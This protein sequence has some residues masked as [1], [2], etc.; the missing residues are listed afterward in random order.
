[1]ALSDP[2]AIY[3]IHSVSPYSRTTGLPYGILKVLDGSSLSLE[4]EII[5]LMGG[6]SK[7]AWASE[8]GAISSDISLKVNQ[9]EDFMFELFLGKAPTANAAE[10]AGNVATAVNKN[11][12]SVIQAVTG[13]ASV[14]VIPSTGAAN[15]K[16]G[17]Y[18]IKVISA[19][20]VKVY[21]LSDVDI[22]RGTNASYADDQLSVTSA[23]LTIT[24]A[25]ST[26]IA[27][28]GIRLSGGSGT[29][30]MTTGDTATFE[31]R[32]I[33]TKSM[34]VSIGSSAD[35][36]FPEFGMIMLAQRRGNQEMFELDALRCKAAG[37][38]FPFERNA[39]SKT[40]L[41]VKAL[42]DSVQ[43]AVFKI[44]SAAAV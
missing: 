24:S 34:T 6:S 15:L 29:I 17:K 2:R 41:K 22:A 1:M 37:M 40:E 43:D 42:Y 7:Y 9:Y 35:S 4:G 13:I 21:L 8:E 16:F 19:T 28:L 18:V 27:D 33:N 12:T 30:G 38:P 11:G 32:P 39:W 14:I 25:T 44:R 3:G 20:T 31:V 23:A 5:D 26:D 36:T 10:T